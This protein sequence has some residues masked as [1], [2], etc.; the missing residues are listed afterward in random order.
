MHQP[1]SQA[2]NPK[3]CWHCISWGGWA[4]GGPR[5]FCRDPRCPKVQA[6]PATGCC[7]F[8]RAPGADDEAGPPPF[9]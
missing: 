5:S 4:W 9:T 3:P 6:S 8:E 2:P 7:S 1:T